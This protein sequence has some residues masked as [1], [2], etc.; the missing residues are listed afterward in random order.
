MRK[1][2]IISL[3]I[4]L[5]FVI[6]SCSSTTTNNNEKLE[7]TKW[8]SD[9][10]YFQE[11][12]EF[13]HPDLFFQIS[14]QEYHKQ[15]NELYESSAE[16]E[17]YEIIIELARITSMM[18]KGRDAHTAVSLFG[19][20]Y[21]HYF[22]IVAMWFSDGLYVFGAKSKYKKA[23]GSKLVKIENTSIEN[24]Q[25]K[26]SDYISHSNEMWAKRNG[27][28]YMIISELLYK[29]GITNDIKKANFVFEDKEG[30]TFSIEITANNN[31]KVDFIP[32]FDNKDKLPLC[33]QFKKSKYYWFEYIEDKE[34]LYVR[35]D[36]CIE[37]E[38]QSFEEFTNE[39]FDFVD[40]NLI[41]KL[42][43]D[44]RHNRGGSS[45]IIWPF[46]NKLQEYPSLNKEDKFFVIISRDTFSSGVFACVYLDNKTEATFIGEPTGG[47]PTGRFG[48]SS[49][50][51]ELP[52]YG[53]FV[54]CSAKYFDLSVFMNVEDTPSFMPDITIELSSDD[55]FSLKDPL[56]DYILT[57]Y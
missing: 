3:L 33:Y 36:K 6:I 52:N 42:V 48:Q 5:S 22:P 19:T 2:I 57:N 31:G 10:R 56:L 32:L 51:F 41:D 11:E 49:N 53:V 15:I 21:F 37:M 45:E 40:N 46:I 28:K 25:A 26:I 7:L 35:Y 50:S 55:F 4:L 24:V 43:L 16:M 44:I 14:K 38:S 12:L 1:L 20:N 29:I 54:S 27:P 30:N 18:V 34:T 47:R 9:I 13:S 23:V 8:Q 39:L 17:D